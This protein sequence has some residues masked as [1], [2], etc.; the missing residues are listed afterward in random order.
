[1]KR[2]TLLMAALLCL[3]CVSKSKYEDIV[4]EK[5]MAEWRV[6]ELEDNE[7]D[8]ERR[9]ETLESQVADMEDIIMR[10][11]WCCIHW[12]NNTDF[13]LAVLNQY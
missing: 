9:I 8:L 7:S 1:M 3:S 10:A 11:K 2:I 5:E 6:R 4:Y 13:A 12:H